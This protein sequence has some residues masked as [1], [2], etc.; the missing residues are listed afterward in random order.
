MLRLSLHRIHTYHQLWQWRSSSLRERER[1]GGRWWYIYNVSSYVRP[2]LT[3]YVL[4]MHWYGEHVQSL[5]RLGPF[6]GISR[7]EKRECVLHE[8][9]PRR[10]KALQSNCAC[11][12]SSHAPHVVVLQLVMETVLRGL[13]ASS[14][15]CK[16]FN[17]LVSLSESILVVSSI[18]KSSSFSNN[19]KKE[20]SHAKKTLYTWKRIVCY[21]RDLSISFS[22]FL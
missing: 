4:V 18:R 9:D 1:E 7:R 11:A 21:H 6:E 20:E 13:C 10:Q 17:I 8:N 15:Y 19:L 2:Y 22:H 14:L 12:K 16:R 5:T 3:Q